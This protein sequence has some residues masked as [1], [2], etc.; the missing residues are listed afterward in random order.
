LGQQALAAGNSGP[1]QEKKAPGDAKGEPAPAKPALTYPRVE[2]FERIGLKLEQFIEQVQGPVQVALFPQQVEEDA[3]EDL[4]VAVLAAFVMKDP[5]VIAQALDAA[6]AGPAPRYV[7]EQLNGGVHYAEKDREADSRPGFWLKGSYLVYVT[8]ADVLLDLA[9]AALAHRTD[10]D[11]IADRPSYKQ[12]VA[13][14]QLDPQALFTIF[15]DADQVLEM[16][17]KLAKVNWQEDDKNPWPPYELVKMLAWFKLSDKSLDSLRAGGVPEPVLSKLNP[18]KNKEFESKEQLLSELA[19]LLDKD[20][21][22]RFQNLVLN[23]AKMLLQNKPVSV[24]FKASPEGIQGHARTPLTFFGMIEAFR[25][26]FI[27]AGFW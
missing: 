24:Q 17:Y 18:L 3:P 13:Q 26:P 14:K 16:P 15:G 7:K 1:P 8:D 20:E 22:Q 9:G 4:P 5:K 27:E 19:K 21:L 23:H 2:R 11:R 6:S 12:A 25:R 10:S